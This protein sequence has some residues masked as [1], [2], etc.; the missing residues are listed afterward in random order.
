MFKIY[1]YA[2]KMNDKVSMHVFITIFR[3]LNKRDKI[4]FI[5]E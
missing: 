2:F 4:N 5:Y 3:Q 1:L